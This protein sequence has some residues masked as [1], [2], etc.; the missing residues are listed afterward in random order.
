[1][2]LYILDVQFA[3]KLT[4]NFTSSDGQSGGVDPRPALSITPIT[5]HNYD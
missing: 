2:V 1:M 5:D 3:D 4:P